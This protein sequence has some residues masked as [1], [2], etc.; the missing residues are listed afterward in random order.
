MQIIYGNTAHLNLAGRQPDLNSQTAL[1]RQQILLKTFKKET[2][3]HAAFAKIP[4]KNILCQFLK[5]VLWEFEV[6]V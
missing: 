4:L 1:N 6:A 3:K 2:N 5:S